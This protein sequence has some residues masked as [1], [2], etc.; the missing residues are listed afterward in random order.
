M[1]VGFQ[2]R[3][4]M[5]PDNDQIKDYNWSQASTKCPWR[6]LAKS[7]TKQPVPVQPFGRAFEGVRM[8]RSVLQI[9]I[10]DVRTSEQHRPDDRS[11]IIQQGVLF[12]KLTLFGKSL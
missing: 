7:K 2:F 11:I 3:I 5:Y 9:N 6:V 12:Q 4:F 1:I 10:E 8:P